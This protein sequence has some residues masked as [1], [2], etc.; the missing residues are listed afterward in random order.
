MKTAGR[1]SSGRAQTNSGERITVGRRFGREICGRGGLGG[2]VR[3]EGFCHKTF[4]GSFATGE[5]GSAIWRGDSSG[6]LRLLLEL[7]R[8]TGGEDEG[9]GDSGRGM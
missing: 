2:D 3:D 9:S 8:Y 6:L 7:T 4:D 1:S 5:A